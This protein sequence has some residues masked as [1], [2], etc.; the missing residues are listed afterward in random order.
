[1]V[2][3]CQSDEPGSDEH[4]WCRR[5]LGEGIVADGF[6]PGHGVFAVCDDTSAA[7]R[8]GH[9]S[10]GEYVNQQKRQGGNRDS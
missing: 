6:D 7:M 2:S 3:E 9:V 4:Q 5:M 1:M 10:V 8:Q